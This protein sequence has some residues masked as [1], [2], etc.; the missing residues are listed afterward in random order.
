MHGFSASYTW[1]HVNAAC[2]CAVTSTEDMITITSVI[3]R[4]L[5]LLIAIWYG[6]R[7]EI[8]CFLYVS[9][10]KVG[11][12]VSV[13]I[14]RYDQLITCLCVYICTCMGGILIFNANVYTDHTFFT[15]DVM[16]LNY[17]FIYMT[18]IYKHQGSHIMNSFSLVGG[19]H[20]WR[21]ESDGA[22]VTRY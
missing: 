14:D 16:E 10:E 3:A 22:L 1:L 6:S 21:Q 20:Q 17:R 13:F 8:H 4:M 15:C 11:R 2:T 9:V 19:Y 5:P 18:C 7:L 12:G